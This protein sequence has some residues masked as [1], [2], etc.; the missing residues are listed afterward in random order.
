MQLR[1]R[2]VCAADVSHPVHAPRLDLPF[3][4]KLRALTVGH[5]NKGEGPDWHLTMVDV[6]EGDSGRR[7]VFVCN[8]WIGLGH[9]EPGAP[10]GVLQRTLLPGGDDPRGHFVEYRVSGGGE[11]WCR[12]AVTA[13][14]ACQ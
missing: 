13:A 1:L 2:A 11:L 5:N 9:P 4:G 10:E 3:V 7:T 6:V 12:H 14:S 8:K